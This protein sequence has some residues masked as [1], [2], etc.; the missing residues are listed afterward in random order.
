MCKAAS[1]S[2]QQ[3]TAFNYHNNS[4]KKSWAFPQHLLYIPVNYVNIAVL[5]SVYVIQRRGVHRE[6]IPLSVR[7]ASALL[8]LTFHIL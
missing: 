6:E 8:K 2:V 5:S 7:A 4:S 1:N 3:T